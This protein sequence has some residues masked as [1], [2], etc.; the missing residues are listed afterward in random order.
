MEINHDTIWDNILALKKEVS[1]LVNSTNQLFVF[2]VDGKL[3][4][5]KDAQSNENK[6]FS[7]NITHK[8]N[9]IFLSDVI[10]WDFSEKINQVPFGHFIKL[11]LPYVFLPI[12]SKQ[13]NR[14]ITISHFAQTLDGKI[15]T[16]S[17]SS[18]WIG[19]SEN[20]LHAHRMRALCEGIMV[21]RQTMLSDKP[22]LN[23]RHCAGENPKKIIV[24]RNNCKEEISGIIGE[25]FIE[26]ST[27]KTGESSKR[28]ISMS[29]FN[30]TEILENLFEKGI[31]SI[32]LEGGSKTTSAFLNCSGLDQIQLHISP[33]VLGS[34][35]SNFSLPEVAN[36]SE[37]VH[38]SQFKF[39]PV[40]DTVMFIGNQ[41]S[42]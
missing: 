27:Q 25:D 41:T 32:Y 36:I 14:A 29:S 39:V 9:S 11:Y 15:A 18:K 33:I 35:V 37:G 38:F 12:A 24:G 23:V 13:L 40:G 4:L 16:N 17:G 34:G 2:M 8:V 26:I 21:G 1:S 6:I 42:N 31:H 30:G 7:L 19:N 5:G 10:S 3:L 22:K 20:L 28:S